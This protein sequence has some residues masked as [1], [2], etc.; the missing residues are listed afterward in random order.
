[1]KFNNRNV[2]ISPKAKLGNNVRIGDNTAI[3]DNVE[4]GDDSVICDNCVIGEP[5][6]AYYSAKTYENPKTII[7]RNA[8]IRSYSI[9]YAGTQAGDHFNTGHRAI[10]R[11]NT[12]MGHY[13]SVG[14]QSIIQGNATLGN[15]TRLHTNVLI[16]T[17]SILG[18]FVY[19][20]PFVCFSNDPHPPSDIV[21]APEVGDFTQVAVHCALLP[22]VKIGKMCLIA[23]NTTV[24][25]DVPDESLVVGNPGKIVGPVSMVKSKEFPGQNHYP[26]MYTFER[27]MPWEGI[28]YDKWK[29]EQSK[30]NDNK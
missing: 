22:G 30:I 17:K 1:M 26:W 9:I 4:I 14:S 7:G 23:A 27:G 20:Y 6:N 24:V 10:V 2:F 18:D 25:R 11:E 16:A 21:L 5:P 15:Y 12:I 19:I 8:M 13:C 3:Y 28:G 29:A